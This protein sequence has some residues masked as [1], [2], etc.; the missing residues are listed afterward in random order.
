[1]TIQEAKKKLLDIAATEEG[2][3]EKA[4]NA[5]LDSKTAMPAETTTRSTLGT[6]PNGGPTMHPSRD[7]PGVICLWTGALSRHSVL[8]SA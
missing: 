4:T 6:M 1:M 8:H 3:L 5:K 7:S 2:Y